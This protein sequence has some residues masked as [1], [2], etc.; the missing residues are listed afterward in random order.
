MIRASKRISLILAAGGAAALALGALSVEAQVL[1]GHDSNAPVD[2]T[3]DRIEVQDRSDRVVVSGNVQVTQG[4]MHLT[5]DRL[6]VAYSQGNGVEI[7]RMDAVGNVVVTR[8][9][10]TAKGNVGIY[11]LDKR[12]I[13]MLGNVQL[14]QGTSRLTGGRLLIDLKTGRSTVDGRSS[15]GGTAVTQG[16][17]GR[18][19]GS[20]K[21]KQQKD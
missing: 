7:N 18:V 10:E 17:G 1:K 8:G 9:N 13:T 15:G 21:V 12:L 20:F 2:F 11:D 16:S 14:T 5:S 3:A 4:N 19:S 6:T